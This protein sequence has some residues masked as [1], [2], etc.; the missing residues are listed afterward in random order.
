VLQPLAML[1]LR[2]R[3]P[4]GL[5]EGQVRAAITAVAKR[6]FSDN[7]NYNDGGYLTL[8]FNGSQPDAANGYTNNGSLYIASLA[9]LPLGLPASHSF[10]TSPAEKWT[11]KK[12]WE[13]DAFPQDH[14][15]SEDPNSLKHL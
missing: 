5:S 8:G 13:G 15:Y 11:S 6:M 10:W 4:E 2:E 7:R 12:A 3:L 1:A 14:Y 9:F